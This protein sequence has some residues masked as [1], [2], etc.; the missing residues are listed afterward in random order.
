[1]WANRILD[2]LIAVSAWVVL[3]VQL[4]TTLV[5]GILVKLT[6]GLLLIPISLVWVV[7]FLGPLLALSWLWGKTPALRVPIAGIGIPLALLGNTYACLMPSMGEMQ[8]RVTKIVLCQTWPFSVQCCAFVT[9]RTVPDS[10][11]A[12]LQLLL[13]ARVQVGPSRCPLPVQ[14][15]GNEAVSEFDAV[16]VRLARKDPAIQQ[17]LCA[18]DS[19]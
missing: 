9:G 2:A 12:L 11:R 19:S 15:Q 4:V 1:M 17:Y 6:F 14:R 10:L 3:P 8:S 13:R 18:F 7:L 5:L 16:L